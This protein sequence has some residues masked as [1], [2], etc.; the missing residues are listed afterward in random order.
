[1][2]RDYNAAMNIRSNLLYRIQNG[3][4][5]PKFSKKNHS[6]LSSQEDIS[7]NM[8][9]IWDGKPTEHPST[10]KRVLKRA[11]LKKVV[12]PLFLLDNI[13]KIVK[14]IPWKNWLKSSI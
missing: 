4:W 6:G 14:E 8:M 3:T 10:L 9:I 1:M 13:N 12:S 7:S 5:D 2:N 11:K